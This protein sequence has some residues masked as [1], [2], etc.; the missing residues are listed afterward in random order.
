M[1]NEARD[2]QEPVERL[3]EWARSQP[4]AADA[5]RV[6]AA[7]SAR[8]DREERELARE[9]RELP[10][11]ARPERVRDRLLAEIGSAESETPAIGGR[12]RFRDLAVLTTAAAALVGVLLSGGA[13]AA[14][15]DSAASI[16]SSA[17]SWQVVLVPACFS[18]LAGV[19][20]LASL[21]LLRRAVDRSPT[22]DLSDTAL[23][24]ADLAGM[25]GSR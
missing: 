18:L 16:F 8:I 21:P 4:P 23:L 20:A 1:T 19:I 13:V 2:P 12:S 9:L 3:L 6:F 14:A 17:A 24:G 15:P 22:A 5:E 10:L 11:G 7:L 25:G